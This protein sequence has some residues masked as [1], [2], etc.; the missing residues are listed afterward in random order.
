MKL[1]L[2]GLR[3]YIQAGTTDEEEDHL[4]VP[5]L[6]RFKGE[7]GERYHLLAVASETASGL[8]PRFWAETLI[9]CRENQG[10][11]AGPA[12]C[13]MDGSQCKMRDLEPLFLEL[14]ETIREEHPKLFD[15]DCIISEDFGLSPSMRRGADTRATLLKLSTRVIETMNRWKTIENARGAAPQL[16]LRERYADIR[17]LVSLMVEFS[18]LF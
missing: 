5:L 13:N 12:I 11:T 18:R 7:T 14:L 16:K 10:L 1:D 6:G 8:T 17:D 4:V 15:L 2:C 9:L 3:K